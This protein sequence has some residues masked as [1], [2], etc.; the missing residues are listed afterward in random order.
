MSTY[1]TR[2]ERLD[3]PVAQALIAALNAE[4][5]QRYPEAGANHFRL[6]A[7]EVGPGRGEFLVAYQGED[8][9]GCGA[10]RRLDGETAEIKRMYVV[11]ELRGRGIGRAVIEALERQA[12]ALGVA[13]L[14]LETGVRQPQAI[15]LY[16]RAGFTTIPAFGAYIGSQ[17]SVCMGKELEARHAIPAVSLINITP[18][19]ARELA[20]PE[21]FER[22]AG[23]TLGEV[24]ALVRETVTQGEEYR[25]EGT[26]PPRWGGYL[27][28]DDQK[29]VVGT[30]AYKGSPDEE[31]AV[32]IAYFT[33]PP[34]ERRG[35]AT[36]MARALMD[37]AVKSREVRRIR[38]HTLPEDNASSRL[39]RRLGFEYAGLAEDP[40]DGPV[41]RWERAVG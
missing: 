11:P 33:F 36:A 26:A 3:A 31:S 37:K 8:A 15:A 40:D 29:R 28:A 39:L 16:R 30:C 6:D 13:R 2:T 14:V 23:V 21:A 17:L 41:W 24:V 10:F 35:Y 18:A 38:A 19:L 4:L 32:E 1:Q 27:A 25:A 9:V 34:Y 5:S 22:K 7:E 20:D 12:R